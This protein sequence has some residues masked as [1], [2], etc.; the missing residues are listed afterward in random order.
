MEEDKVRRPVYYVSRVMRGAEKRYPQTEKF[1]YALI[2]AVRKLKP[3]FEAHP[4]EVVT[5]QPLR[6]F[7]RTPIGPD[8]KLESPWEGPYIIQRIMGPVTYELETLE[9]RQV[10]RSWNVCHLR[11]YYV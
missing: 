3:Y 10:P 1:V 8:G 5:D 7:W 11:K 2:I 6:K 9:G 4:L